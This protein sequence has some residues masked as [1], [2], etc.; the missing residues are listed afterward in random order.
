MNRP[1]AFGVAW[2]PRERATLCFVRVGTEVLLIEK[3][4]GLGGGKVN[5]PGGKLEPGESPEQAAIRETQEEVGVTP[6]GLVKRAELRFQ[7]L[8]GYSMEC[9]VFVA[10]GL[11]GEPHETA[12][13]KPFWAA[14]SA[15]PYDRM[16]EDD[17]H[18]LG[19]ALAGE[20]LR[21]SFEF[22]EDRMTAMEIEV[23]TDCLTPDR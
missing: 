7:F 5:G 15:L 4:R 19:R 8:D 10:D 9:T 22:D 12:E 6:S 18:W 14:I 2:I 11:E 1:T 13:A 21:G 16:W 3:K 23:M 17:R 20:N